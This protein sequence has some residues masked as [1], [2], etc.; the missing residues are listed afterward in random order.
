MLL[1]LL[2]N[3]ISSTIKWAPPLCHAL[4]WAFY[5]D[6]CTHSFL[7]PSEIYILRRKLSSVIFRNLPRSWRL[8]PHLNPGHPPKFVL[9]EEHTLTI[10]K[11]FQAKTKPCGFLKPRH[12]PGLKTLLIVFQLLPKLACYW[13]QEHEGNLLLVYS[14]EMALLSWGP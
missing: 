10:L 2:I 6:Y 1:L 11:Y 5:I 9:C 13:W 8:E 14:K 3:S 4:G 7:E 12:I